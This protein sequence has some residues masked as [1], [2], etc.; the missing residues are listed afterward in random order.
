MA[1]D[2]FLRQRPVI[3]DE[4]QKKLM[5]SSVLIA[6]GGGL[7]TNVAQQLVRLGIG[8]IHMVDNGVIDS[9]DLNRQILYYRDDNPR[10]HLLDSRVWKRTR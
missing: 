10:Q 1:K 6:G 7:G 3:G 2:F 8:S 9:S 4:C 5:G